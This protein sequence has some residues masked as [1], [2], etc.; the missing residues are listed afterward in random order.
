MTGEVNSGGYVL[1]ALD[2]NWG[3]GQLSFSEKVGC[4]AAGDELVSLERSCTYA[5]PPTN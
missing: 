2:E 1:V 4:L 5:T 3:V